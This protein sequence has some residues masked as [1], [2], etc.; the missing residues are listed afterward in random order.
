MTFFKVK[1][2]SN[3]VETSPHCPWTVVPTARFSQ[4]MTV[5]RYFFNTSQFLID[6]KFLYIINLFTLLVFSK[7]VHIFIFK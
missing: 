7:F 5:A 4:G 1:T 6:I 2:S 3:P